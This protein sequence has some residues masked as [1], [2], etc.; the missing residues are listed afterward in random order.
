MIDELKALLIDELNLEGLK[1]SDID[2]HA[3]MFGEGLGLDS[4]DAL[5]LAVILDRKYG[6]KIK[7]K[8]SRNTE[9]FSSLTAL[10]GFVSENRAR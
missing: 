5:E 1:S 10:A 3:P 7:A 6:I 8:D 2:E 9:I 4:I